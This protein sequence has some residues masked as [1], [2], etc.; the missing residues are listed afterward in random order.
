MTAPTLT[1]STPHL[2]L[3]AEL[4]R[5]IR[6]T[7]DETVNVI[8]PFTGEPL[9]SLPVSSTS[10][11]ADAYALARLA[12]IAWA[13]AGF[14]HRR[15]V[16]LRA[17]DLLLARREAVLDTLQT[18]TGKTRGQAFEEIFQS[19]GVTFGYFD[20]VDLL[21][22]AIAAVLGAAF[23]RP[24]YAPIHIFRTLNLQVVLFYGVFLVVYLSH[25]QR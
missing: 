21:L 16:L 25:V 9:H 23:I 3:A 7:T 24:P 1:A 2:T 8:G 4:V 12:Q 15:A 17:H 6:S 10:D 20:G 5:D 19:A 14:A 18:E 13:R 22:C 11:V